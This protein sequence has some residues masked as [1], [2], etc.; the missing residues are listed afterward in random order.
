MKMNNRYEVM[1]KV[2]TTLETDDNRSILT[3]L[4]DSI[5]LFDEKDQF[6]DAVLYDMDIYENNA[7]GDVIVKLL[8]DSDLAQDDFASSVFYN[9]ESHLV[10]QSSFEQVR[11]TD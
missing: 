8:V 1:L 9:F 11:L 4:E 7:Q 6:S 10:T 3:Q 5:V 2:T